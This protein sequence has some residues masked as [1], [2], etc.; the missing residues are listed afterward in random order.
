MILE[1]NYDWIQYPCIVQVL[2]FKPLVQIIY[3]QKIDYKGWPGFSAVVVNNDYF[4]LY[5]TVPNK[6]ES[7]MRTLYYNI[8]YVYVYFAN[9]PLAF[10]KKK[11]DIFQ[12]NIRYCNMY[13]HNVIN[14]DMYCGF[15]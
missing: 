14:V 13:H 3:G 6:R 7:S 9:I 12:R 11:K 5:S 10:L 2:N 4:L 8:M 1:R 15:V